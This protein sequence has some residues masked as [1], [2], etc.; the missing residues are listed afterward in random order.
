LARARRFYW[1]WGVALPLLVGLGVYVFMLVITGSQMTGLAFGAGAG[2]AV[3]YV[4]ET[5]Y[6]RRQE[7]GKWAATPQAR[8]P[9]SS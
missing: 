6:L 5:F 3:W 8:R 1:L 2:G 7:K 9:H 4:A